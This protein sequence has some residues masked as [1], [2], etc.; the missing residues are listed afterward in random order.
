M[1]KVGAIWAAGLD[2]VEKRWVSRWAIMY[3]GSLQ[4]KDSMV[5]NTHSIVTKVAAGKV[6]VNE[7]NGGSLAKLGMF[8]GMAIFGHSKSVDNP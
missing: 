6:N 5:P 7:S 8:K 1:M 4:M 3:L 2:I